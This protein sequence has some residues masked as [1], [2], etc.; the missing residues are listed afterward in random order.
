M[1]TRQQARKQLQESGHQRTRQRERV[2]DLCFEHDGHFTADDLLSYS[3]D[4]GESLS[5]ATVY[6]T[7]HLLVEIGVLRELPETGTASC[8]ELNRPAHPHA[9]C[10]V[11]GEIVDLEVDLEDSLRQV[12]DDFAAESVHVIIEGTCSDCSAS[13]AA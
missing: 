5:R 7:L 2:V 11:C 10:R 9:V 6:N 13:R 1:V 8:Y 3:R 12:D 4:R